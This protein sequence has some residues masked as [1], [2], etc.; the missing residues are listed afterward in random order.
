MNAEM[1]HPGKGKVGTV[2][3]LGTTVECGG[4]SQLR[5]GAGA[6]GRKERD[7]LRLSRGQVTGVGRPLGRGPRC[8]VGILE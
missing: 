2:G 4:A 5:W 6:L 8:V 3:D 1:V 7:P